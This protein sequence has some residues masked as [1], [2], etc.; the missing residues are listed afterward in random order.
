M[1]LN[2]QSESRKRWSSLQGRGAVVGGGILHLGVI[3]Q[4]MSS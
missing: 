1:R 2:A 3:P 4:V